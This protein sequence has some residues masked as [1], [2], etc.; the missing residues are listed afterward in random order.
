[1]TCQTAVGKKHFDAAKFC[2]RLEIFEQRWVGSAY[3]PV[4][5]GRPRRVERPGDG[6]RGPRVGSGRRVRE[7]WSRGRVGRA[8]G[9][10]RGNGAA[11]EPRPLVAPALSGA[12]PGGPLTFFCLPGRMRYHRTLWCHGSRRRPSHAASMLSSWDPGGKTAEGKGKR[13]GTGERG[14]SGAKGPHTFTFLT[15]SPS[16]RCSILQEARSSPQ[17][18]GKGRQV[19]PH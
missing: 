7:L 6:D 18:A 15:A 10:G 16:S 3:S 11:E 2:R 17:A 1:M 9:E 12:F 5:W 13:G 14:D 8:G 4:Y 19:R